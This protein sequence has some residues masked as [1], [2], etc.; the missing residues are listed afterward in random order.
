MN[1][2]TEKTRKKETELHLSNTRSN[3]ANTANRLQYLKV[4]A[5]LVSNSS[6]DPAVAFCVVVST[7]NI[8]PSVVLVFVLFSMG[9]GVVVVRNDVV[10]D[11]VVCNDVVVMIVVVVGSGVGAGVGSGVA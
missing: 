1:C 6:S 3:N 7:I 2:E 8:D 10:G 11:D 4:V 5:V 9:R